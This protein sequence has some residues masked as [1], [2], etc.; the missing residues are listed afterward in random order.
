MKPKLKLPERFALKL[1]VAVE[2]TERLSLLSEVSGGT[3]EVVVPYCI[4]TPRLMLLFSLIFRPDANG[5]ENPL[6]ASM[7]CCTLSE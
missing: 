7:V 1:Y 5:R 6:V 2:V 4:V 3:S